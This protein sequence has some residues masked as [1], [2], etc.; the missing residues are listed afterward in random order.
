VGRMLDLFDIETGAVRRWEGPARK[1]QRPE[2]D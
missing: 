2:A 1:G